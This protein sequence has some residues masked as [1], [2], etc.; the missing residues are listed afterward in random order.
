LADERLRGAWRYSKG[1]YDILA[2]DGKLY[3]QELQLKGELQPEGEWLV[4]K[5]AG[6]GTIRLKLHGA[7]DEVLSNFKV[8][9]SQD[10]GED[11]VAVSEWGSLSTKATDLESQLDALEFTGAAA[12]N[13]VVVTVD[14]RQRPKGVQLSAEAAARVADLG[15]LVEQAYASAAEASMAASTEKLRELYAGHFGIQAA[16]APAPA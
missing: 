16:P 8:P 7:G 6:A 3:F 9:D 14:G 15:P 10:W 11:V 12:D 5:L 2:E 13:A 4:A 1:A